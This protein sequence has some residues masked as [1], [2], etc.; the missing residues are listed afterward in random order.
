MI[1]QLNLFGDEVNQN[2]G[3]K[4]VK[5]VISASR[6][7][8][9]PAF[10]Y[11][12]LQDTLAK[13]FVEVPNPMFPSKKYTI[14]LRPTSV[15]SIVLWSKDFKNV[16]RNPMNLNEYN[17]YFQYTINNYSKFLE[18]N[19]PSYKETLYTLDG[20]LKKYMPEQ[21]NIR[22]DPVIISTKGEISPT[23][24][25]PERARINAF[26]QLCM[27]LRSL[28]MGNCRV[29]TS[30]ISMYGHI[31]DKIGKGG[32]DIIHFNEDEQISF[33][34]QMAEIAQKYDISLYSCAS[35]ILE[36]VK[37]INRGHCID[38]ELLEKLFGGK[39][40]KSKDRGQRETCGCTY[41][42]EIGIYSRNINGMKCLHGCK[43][44]YVVD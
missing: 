36:K 22:F 27:N 37:G 20:L 23:L 21:F 1:N 40:K 13:G 15:H 18:P 29:T 5:T 30:Y 2:K 12:W 11:E 4:Q 34:T 42:R 33:F 44:C 43:Y 38:G 3:L 25:M 24:N 10:F 14:D 35:P 19:V 39:V 16:L 32:L 41:S 26:E 17:L 8:D 7:T 31:R 9:I 28:G 6:R